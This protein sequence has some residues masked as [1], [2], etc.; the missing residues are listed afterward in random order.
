MQS[1]TLRFVARLVTFLTTAGVLWVPAV[2]AAAE[3]EATD[4][5]PVYFNFMLAGSMV[6]EDP[7]NRVTHRER[8]AFATPGGVLR[9]GGVLGR[10]HLLGAILQ[11]NWRSTRQVLDHAGNDRRWGAISSYFLGPEYRYLTRFGLYAGGSLG[12]AYT[13][14]DDDVGGGGSPD[15]SWYSC[16]ARH[17]RETDDQGIPGVGVRAVVGYELRVRRNLAVNFEGFGGV[18]HGEDEDDVRMTIPTYGLAVGVG[19]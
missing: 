12:F 18:L 7:D 13:L 14:V 2:A 3:P 10:H 15:C 19:F 6:H 9:L 16:V 5:P 4:R 1:S 11:V 17:M 8:N